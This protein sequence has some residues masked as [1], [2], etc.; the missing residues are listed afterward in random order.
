MNASILQLTLSMEQQESDKDSVEGED[1]EDITVC[2]DKFKKNSML[3]YY[4]TT[5]RQP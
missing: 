2:L 1:M 5:F 4:K 3:L